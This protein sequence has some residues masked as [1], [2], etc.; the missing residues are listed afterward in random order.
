MYVAHLSFRC[1]PETGLYIQ[2][3]LCPE[4]YG[5]LVSEHSPFPAA[6]TYLPVYQPLLWLRYEHYVAPWA[7]VCAGR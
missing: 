6:T 5:M 3:V 2:A 7:A 1:S 4:G